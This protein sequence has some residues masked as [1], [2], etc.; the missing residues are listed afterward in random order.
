MTEGCRKVACRTINAQGDR[1]FCHDGEKSRQRRFAGQVEH[2]DLSGQPRDNFNQTGSAHAQPDLL[3]LRHKLAV[4]RHGGAWW[5]RDQL[6]DKLLATLRHDGFFRDH[7][8][9]LVDRK[10]RGHVG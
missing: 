5:R 2:S 4:S 7:Q 1:A 9:R 3:P 6:D 10:N 8:G